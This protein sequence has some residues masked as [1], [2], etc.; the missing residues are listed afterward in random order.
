MSG[1]AEWMCTREF[2]NEVLESR[3]LLLEGNRTSAPSLAEVN[4]LKGDRPCVDGASP[5]G[6]ADTG[7]AT[8]RQGQSARERTKP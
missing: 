2:I 6:G 8:G 5:R 3:R 7:R 4:T 1:A